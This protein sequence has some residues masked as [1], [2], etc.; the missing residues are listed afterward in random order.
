MDFSIFDERLK[1]LSYP[2]KQLE[3][4]SQDFDNPV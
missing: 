4:G 2:Y 3:G 1:D